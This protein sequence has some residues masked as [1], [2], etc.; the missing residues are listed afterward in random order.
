[1]AL[2]H[3]AATV[4]DS[5]A[6][7][8]LNHAL[9]RDEGHRNPMSVEQLK[10]RMRGWLASSEYR[11]VLFEQDGET[12]GYALYRETDTE[13]YLRQFFVVAERRRQGLGRQAMARLVS[14]WPATKRRTVSVLSANARALAFWRAMGYV[15]Y[16]VTLEMV[17]RA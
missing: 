17:P 12:V 7:A 16:D 15:D 14:E 2:T 9:I 5:P 1:M 10:A 6:L 4:E 3:R 13:I 11:A 8:V